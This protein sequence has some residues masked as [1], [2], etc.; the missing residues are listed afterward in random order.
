MCAQS[1]LQGLFQELSDSIDRQALFVPSVDLTPFAHEERLQ[2][3]PG[4]ERRRHRRY[5]LITNVITLPLDEGLRPISQPV[6]S[7]SSGMSVSGIR[8]LHTDPLPSDYLFIE[9][10]GQPVRFVLCVLRTRSI[11]PYVEI[12]GQF[13]DHRQFL[14]QRA[15]SLRAG[16][17]A[18]LTDGDSLTRLPA[19]SISPFQIA[20]TADELRHWEGVAAA[21]QLPTSTEA[22]MASSHARGN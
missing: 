21:V 9:I 19:S 3:Q 17:A 22:N 6:V 13:L 16:S 11:G 12:A 18:C 7:L 10:E 5:S 1:R 14:D 4:E 20:P 2:Q 15:V 8:L